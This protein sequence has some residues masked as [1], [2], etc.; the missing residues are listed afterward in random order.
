MREDEEKTTSLIVKVT[1]NCKFT[2]KFSMKK[3]CFACYYSQETSRTN[4]G[5]WREK[6]FLLKKTCTFSSTQASDN[7]FLSQLS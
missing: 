2:E 6:F 3:Y 4:D 5:I 7:H 1:F